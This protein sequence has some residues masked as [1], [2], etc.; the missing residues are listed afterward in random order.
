M[1]SREAQ[2]NDLL[3]RM[4]TSPESIRRLTLK[5]EQAEVA[6]FG[7]GV[8]VSLNLPTGIECSSAIKQKLNNAGFDL[9]YTP[10]MRDPGHHTVIFPQPLTG[11]VVHLFN[12][13]LR[14]IL[15]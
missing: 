7:F 6:G 4:G 10:T 15:D 14:R 3:Y 13:V 8:S 9:N 11:E 2:D 5:C 12:K 1:F